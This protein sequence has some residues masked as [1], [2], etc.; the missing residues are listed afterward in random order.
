[1]KVNQQKFLALLVAAVVAMPIAVNA[2][3]EF[4]FATNGQ[5]KAVIVVQDGATNGLRTAANLLSD[6]L[7]RMTGARFMVTDRPVSGFN[8]I[9]GEASLCAPPRRSLRGVQRRF[10]FLCVLCGKILTYPLL[11]CKVLLLCTSQRH[12]T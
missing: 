2:A 1:M 4:L 9:K 7:G 11:N 12:K 8:T 6:T 3:H 5:A 10:N